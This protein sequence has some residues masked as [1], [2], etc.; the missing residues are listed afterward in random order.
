MWSIDMFVNHK[1]KLEEMDPED[2]E[3]GKVRQ[4]YREIYNEL[5]K[6]KKLDSF[7]ERMIGGIGG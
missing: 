1:Q 5:E 6:D 2:Y 7:M 3:D 4:I